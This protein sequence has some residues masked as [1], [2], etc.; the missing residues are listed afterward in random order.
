M[1][2]AMTMEAAGQAINEQ[3]RRRPTIT[4]NWRGKCAPVPDFV[5]ADEPVSTGIAPVLAPAPAP[6]SLVAAPAPAALRVDPWTAPDPLDY[7][8]E[9]W[10]VWMAGDADRDLGTKTMR[11]LAGGA[12]IE[13]ADEAPRGPDVYE[14]QQQHETRIAAAT[15]AMIDSLPRIQAWAIYRSCSMSTAWR[16]PNADLVTAAAEARA[17]LTA[18]LKKNICTGTLF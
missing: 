16:F 14:A 17:A 9:C 1:T 2:A 7:C 10:K 6:A 3:A 11:G 18:L 15:D 4:L 8:L 5:P 12:D 13:D